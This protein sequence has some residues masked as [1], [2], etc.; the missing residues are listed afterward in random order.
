MLALGE[1]ETG[2]C[3]GC[4]WHEQLADQIHVTADTKVCPICAG[5][6]RWRRVQA[7]ADK[8]HRDSQG[9]DP[10]PRAPDPADGRRTRTRVLTADEVEAHEER[11]R[12]RAA[13]TGATTTSSAPSDVEGR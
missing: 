13:R 2:V 7:A 5:L 4:G 1:Y 12:Q 11:Q 10:D 8:A 6:D 3:E 9:G